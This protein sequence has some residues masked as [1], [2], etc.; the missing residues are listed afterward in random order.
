MKRAIKPAPYL[1]AAICAATLLVPDVAASARPIAAP[2]YELIDVGTFG[3]PQAFL[4][5]PAELITRSGAAL[6][7]ADTTIPDADYPNFNP[8]VVGIPDPTLAHAFSWHDG[9]LHDLGALPGNNSSAVFEVNT[10]GVGAGLS[11]LETYDPFTQYQV[12]H[13]VLFQHGRV[14]DLGTLPGG[15]QSQAIAI[16]DNSLVAGFGNNGV[17]DP[18]SVFPWR[19]QTR[20]FVWQHGQLRDLG[21]LGGPDTLMATMNERGQVAGDSYTDAIVQPATGMPTSRPFLWQRGRMRDLG[22][23]GGTTSSTAWL[24][25]RGEVVGG[26]NL[27]GDHTRHPFLWDGWRLRDLGTLGGT[28][29]FASRISNN[30][31]VV[32]GTTVP[33]DETFHAFMWRNGTMIDLARTEDPGCSFAEAVNVHGDAV[34]HNCFETQAYLWHGSHQYDL[35][36]MVGPTDVQLTVGSWITDRGDIAALGQLP[37]GGQHVFLLRPTH[38]HAQQALSAAGTARSAAT[39]LRPCARDGI[40]TARAR[41]PVDAAIT[42]WLPCA[43]R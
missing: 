1:L 15:T 8:F 26:S 41:G 34:G 40:P 33:G 35:T 16:N 22:T 7:S 9:R 27:A 30:G 13:A 32:G 2:Q 14:Q 24:N 20:S 21:S 29:G 6:G 19:T 3:G 5:A 31:I 28:L 25:D 42:R 4:N 12:D 23:L 17:P 39:A 36:S 43:R 37:N 38:R 18:V 11:E 10:D